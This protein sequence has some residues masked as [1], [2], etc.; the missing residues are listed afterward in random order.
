[1]TSTAG[2]WVFIR[3]LDVWRF[4]DARP[5][6]AG[7][8]YFARTV[9][10]PYPTT[11][12]GAIRTYYLHTQ[13][14]LLGSATDMAGLQ[15]TGPFIAKK[16]GETVE[17][18]FSM[19]LDV[20][21]GKQNGAVTLLHPERTRSFSANVPDGWHPLT[22]QQEGEF[23][24]AEGWLSEN[25]FKAYLE[26][27]KDSVQITSSDQ[28]FDIEDRIGLGM[29]H[30]RRANEQG[31]FYRAQFVRP[32]TDVG[33]LLHVNM[34]IFQSKTG[35]IHLGGESRVGTFE[36]IDY[37][38]PH[39]AVKPGKIKLVL[40]TP[41]YF[42]AGWQ[43]EKGWGAWLGAGVQFISAA[44][45]KPLSI[46]GWDMQANQGRGAPK[47]LRHFLPSGSVFYFDNAEVPT[48]PFTETPENEPNFAAVGYGAFAASNWE[49]PA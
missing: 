16:T 7:Q 12:Q 14:E 23:D 15:I 5:F 4:R 31:L 46:S 32:C 29:D 21:Q 49:Y 47:P 3:A 20:L 35:M 36:V 24:E 48:T 2:Q 8:N 10:P 18:Y 43:P 34:P 13:G 26:G 38:P 45:G 33:L 37:A 42:H 25:S 41:A 1:M 19:P 11:M 9:F 17:R 28:L 27:H 30:R 6:S 39:Y 40:L 22:V 44:I